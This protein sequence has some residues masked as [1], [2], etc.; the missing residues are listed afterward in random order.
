MSSK[1]DA[2]FK[3][4]VGGNYT[5]ESLQKALAMKK[6]EIRTEIFAGEKKSQQSIKKLEKEISALNKSIADLFGS[7]A[8]KGTSAKNPKKTFEKKQKELH[9]KE[10]ELAQ[11]KDLLLSPLGRKIH[12]IQQA[13]DDLAVEAYVAVEPKSAKKD[14]LFLTINKKIK[15]AN[16][17]VAEEIATIQQ[18]LN[19]LSHKILAHVEEIQNLGPK[20]V[21]KVSK[22]K[23]KDKESGKSIKLT[24]AINAQQLNYLETEQEFDFKLTRASKTNKKLTTHLEI[25]QELDDTIK[26]TLNLALKDNP[27]RRHLKNLRNRLELELQFITNPSSIAKT[28][29]TAVAGLGAGN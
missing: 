6:N 27:K 7:A 19:S 8:A 23:V 20:I 28:T 26:D 9:K 5:L 4:V 24:E 16:E 29:E 14:N 13:I 25:E 2:Y 15:E 17:L 18:S 10:E 21:K 11:K 22:Q 3:K 12:V 1:A